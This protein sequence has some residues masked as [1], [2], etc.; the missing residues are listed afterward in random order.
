MRE[1]LEIAA[2]Q[3]AIQRLTNEQIDQLTNG[4][5]EYDGE[6]YD[7]S[8]DE[9]RRFHSL[10]AQATGNEELV[11]MLERVHDLLA[12]FLFM[13]FVHS[14]K[15]QGQVHSRIIEAFY[16]RDGERVIQIMTDDIRNTAEV[17]LRQ[18]MEEQ[19]SAW[20]IGNLETDRY[21]Y[22]GSAN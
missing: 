12:R 16:S 20:Q 15:T 10:I 17:I 6:S 19:G 5:A 8:V 13:A 14:N 7:K 21:Y 18:I 1:I 2:C 22:L 4:R 3:L 11:K 9:N